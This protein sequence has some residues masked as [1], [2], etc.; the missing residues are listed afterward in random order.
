MRLALRERFVLI[1]SVCR[2]ELTLFDDGWNAGE[3][4]D[5]R[6]PGADV[7]RLVVISLVRPTRLDRTFPVMLRP[8]NPPFDR[9]LCSES[10]AL[11]AHVDGSIAEA[12][13]RPEPGSAAMLP[14]RIACPCRPHPDQALP[15]R[16]V[17][18]SPQGSP[19]MR[20]TRIGRARRVP[21]TRVHRAPLDAAILDEVSRWKR[22]GRS[23]SSSPARAPPV[24]EA[25][26]PIPS[27]LVPTRGTLSEEG[28]PRLRRVGRR[29][30]Q[31][32]A[33]PRR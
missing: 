27:P 13:V 20:A 5:Q 14:A 8:L 11:V 30:T 16:A 23:P 28:E 17:N 29:A 4:S 9:G 15:P 7:G 6:R 2:G 10:F 25:P 21:F 19:T 26:E 31:A 18:A 12:V 33:S 22:G 1:R 3:P 32:L 24:S